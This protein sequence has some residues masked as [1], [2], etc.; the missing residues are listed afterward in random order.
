MG[1]GQRRR[2]WPEMNSCTKQRFVCCTELLVHSQGSWGW[3]WL[4][5]KNIPPALQLGGP[6]E[7]RALGY[8]DNKDRFDCF[9]SIL[10][11]YFPLT[12]KKKKR[13]AHTHQHVSALSGWSQ[14]KAPWKPYVET[15]PVSPVC[16]EETKWQQPVP[17]LHTNMLVTVQRGAQGRGACMWTLET[18]GNCL[19]FLRD[20]EGSLYWC[21][22]VTYAAAK[23]T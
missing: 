1:V 20:G 13:R 5:R 17:L 11:S 21:P 15:R 14:R 4:Q 8:C 3:G 18:G 6:R 7:P 9:W 16:S 12:K 19:L 22:T 10:R 23:E 2:R